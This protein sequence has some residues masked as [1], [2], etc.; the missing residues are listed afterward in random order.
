MW[1][2]VAYIG[3]TLGV[4]ALLVVIIMSIKWD[5]SNMV[6]VVTGRGSKKMIEKYRDEQES[7]YRENGTGSAPRSTHITT[8]SLLERSTGST[9]DLDKA[10]KLTKSENAEFEDYSKNG[11]KSTKIG[12]NLSRNLNSLKTSI[13]SINK[14]GLTAKPVK[15][16]D[17]DLVS[18]IQ[19]DENLVNNDIARVSSGSE[20]N[21]EEND[22]FSDKTSLLE[23]NED[24]KTDLLIGDTVEKTDL[25]VGEE[26]DKT[27]ILQDTEDSGTSNGD[28]KTSLLEEESEKDVD[29]GG[30]ESLYDW[31]E[32]TGLEDDTDEPLDEPSRIGN[33]VT[34]ILTEED[35]D[36]DSEVAPES[37][38]EGVA[39]EDVEMQV[40]VEEEL[41][42]E[43]EE[44][45]DDQAGK[46]QIMTGSADDF[47][48]VLKE[49]Y[50]SIEFH[51]FVVL[52]VVSSYD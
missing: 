20:V 2:T 38:S 27:S 10:S 30:S 24:T 21:H 42:D 29:G 34:S 15:A 26:T 1:L 50:E 48:K 33:P 3:F 40:E 41:E 43:S 37:S 31:F 8:Q 19:S 39:E 47:K 13:K 32:S 17:T 16:S 9:R 12:M 44:V 25:L 14:P 36:E 18:S 35:T 5:V 22:N 51:E 7:G 45:N 49:D 28:D 46:T 6:R 23:E 4:I 52:E 11:S